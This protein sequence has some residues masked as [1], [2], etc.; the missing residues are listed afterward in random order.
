[1][2]HAESVLLAFGIVEKT[3]PLVRSTGQVPPE[4]WGLFLCLVLP[5]P[6]HVSTSKRYNVRLFCT[7]FASLGAIRV[8]K[9]KLNKKLTL[10]GYEYDGE[11]VTLYLLKLGNH[12]NSYRDLKNSLAE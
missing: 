6:R 10:L 4:A 2:R 12:E 9:F 3:K 7:Q 8:Y 1:L 11:T 5:N